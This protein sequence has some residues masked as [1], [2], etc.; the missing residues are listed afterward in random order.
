MLL[1]A[2]HT[3]DGGVFR[4]HRDVITLVMTVLRGGPGRR[5]WG[6]VGLHARGWSA[7][8][9]CGARLPVHRSEELTDEALDGRA[10]AVCDDVENV[11]YVQ[12]VLLSWFLTQ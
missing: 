5:A 10:S 8:A 12:K 9:L 11:P 6:T 1:R 2:G 3:F 4:E 7:S